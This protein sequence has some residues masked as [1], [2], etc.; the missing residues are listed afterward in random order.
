MS[1]NLFLCGHTGSQNRGCEAIVRS[2]IKIFKEVGLKSKPFLATSAVRQ[3]ENAKVHCLAELIPYNTYKSKFQRAFFAGLRKLFSN[4]IIGQSIIQ[5]KLWNSIDAKDL[6]LA[7]GGDTYCYSTP[8]VFLAHNRKMQKLGVPSILWCCSVGKENLNKNIIDD[9]NRY[10]LIVVREE[11]TYKA[12]KEAGIPEDKLMKCCDPAFLLDIKE[13]ELP[14]NFL[15]GNTVGINISSLVKNEEVYSSVDYLIRTI[16]EDT[17]MNICFVPHVYGAKIESGDL[18]LLREFYNKY[19]STNRVSIVDKDLSCEELKFIISNCR[20]FAGARTHSTIAA[21]STM[22]PTLVLGYSIKSK[23]IAKD[24]FGTDKGYVLPYTEIKEK[25]DI[26]NAFSRIFE[27]ETTIKEHYK[28]I[29]PSYTQT[30]RDTAKILYNRYL[31]E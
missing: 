28:Q 11:Y 8:T 26:Y 14:N 16:L 5:K 4:P 20:F 1:K 22:V 17:D 2:T 10:S 18:K 23:G 12:L 19:S 3:D 30:V 6:S 24:L 27:A 25:E 29:L 31:G 21:Y 15:A 7:I 13:C 9:L